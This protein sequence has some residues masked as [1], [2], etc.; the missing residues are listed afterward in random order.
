MIM[1]IT[2]VCGAKGDAEDG[3]GEYVDDFNMMLALVEG[4][5]ESLIPGMT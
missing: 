4:S 5:L 2:A 1:L 3:A